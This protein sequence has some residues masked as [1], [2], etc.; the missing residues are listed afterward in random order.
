MEEVTSSLATPPEEGMNMD[1][2]QVPSDEPVVRKHRVSERGVLVGLWHTKFR[3]CSARGDGVFPLQ[4]T[5][6]TVYRCLWPCCGKMLTSEVG[7]KRHI[8]TTHLR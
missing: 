6:K 7:I 4:C 5:G 3:L 1:L 8:R 2:D